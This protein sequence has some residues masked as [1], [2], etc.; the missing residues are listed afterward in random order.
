MKKSGLA[1]PIGTDRQLFLDELF[2]DDREGVEMKVN[3]P[4]Q[5]FTPVMV[6]EGPGEQSLGCYNT[7]LR[8][9][10]RFRMWYDAI[11]DAEGQARRFFCYAESGDGIHWEK[12]EL[13]MVGFQG[14]HKNNIVAPVSPSAS[15][16]GGTVFRDDFGPAEERFKLWTKYQAGDEDRKQGITT[17]LWAMV[18]PDGLRWRLLREGYPL[19]RGNAADT[20]SICFRDD[21]LGQYVGF[22]RIKKFPEGR[23]RTCSVGLMTSADFRNWTPAKTIFGPDERDE[24]APV[25]QGLPE[26]RPPVDFYVPGGMKIPGVPGA[27]VILPNAYY[28]WREDAFPSTL[29][30]RIAASRNLEHWWQ[31]P[32]RAPFL[33][34]GPDGSAASGMIFANPHLIPVGD[35]LWLY[36]SGAGSDHRGQQGDRSKTGIFRARLRRDGFISADAGYG[37]GTFTTPTLTFHGR[38]LEL[39]MDGSAGGWLQ[40]EILS[41]EGA[42]I[43]EFELNASDAIRGNSVRKTVTWKSGQD[44]SDLAGKPVRLRFVMRS[45]KL[46][47][48]QFVE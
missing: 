4:H 19:N 11:T 34:L 37:G 32:D 23:Q 16:Q 9:N 21:D 18:S 17:G 5:D 7:V 43:P 27:Y 47:S 31:P 14:S 26:W 30:V 12:P 1:I 20:Q 44:V 15:Q 2:F 33:R 25:P 29:D 22:V 10:G 42:H 46:F 13:G 39:N 3:P 40:V 48:F 45:M 35:E 24:N 38:R 28:H 6:A 36:Y 8:E 41:A